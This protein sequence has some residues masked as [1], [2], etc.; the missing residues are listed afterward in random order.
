ME[1]P[2][3]EE[4]ESGCDKEVAPAVIS[5]H[6]LE[7]FVAVAVGSELRVFDING[8]R[9]VSL[10][11]GS[12]LPPHTD[13]IRAICFGAKGRFF[14]SAGDDKL[15]KVWKTD[16][17]QCVC[18]V[19]SEKRVTA[20]SVSHDGLFVTFAD[21]FGVIWVASLV[22]DGEDQMSVHR[23]AAPLLGHYCSIITSLEYSPDGKFI[24]TADRDFKIRISVFPK[25]PLTGAHEI[26]SY[27]LGHTDYVSCLAFVCTPNYPEGFLLSGSGDSTV[28]STLG[29]CFWMPS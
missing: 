10:L 3:I 17:W 28:G 27:C 29:F 15:V 13:S 1:D 11:D 5:V 21:K 9:T 16:S 19:H 7:S 12:G 4:C 23:K 24:A 25:R 2:S 8:D 6:P 22:D 20:V 18:T 26:Q 14:A